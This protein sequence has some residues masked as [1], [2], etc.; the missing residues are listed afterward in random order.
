MRS[1]QAYLRYHICETM[2]KNHSP[3]LHLSH[4]ALPAGDGNCFYRA[5]IAAG[6]EVLCSRAHPMWLTNLS[7]A[8]T[9][10]YAALSAWTLGMPP[11]RFISR[12]ISKCRY[13]AARAL[14]MPV[15][16]VHTKLQ[17][18][19]RARN[20]VMTLGLVSGGSCCE[21]TN[22]R[23]MSSSSPFITLTDRLTEGDRQPSL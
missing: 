14:D 11:T 16:S 22:C 4:A 6:L 21:S 8:V 18:V 15:A 23:G 2:V 20:R 19:G 3:A 9:K 17:Q 10:E 1:A 7:G 12:T 13:S 5:Y